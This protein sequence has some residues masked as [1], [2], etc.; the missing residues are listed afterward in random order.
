MH[1]TADITLHG[2]SSLMG[3][4]HAGEGFLHCEDLQAGF[5]WTHSMSSGDE[6]LNVQSNLWAT[7]DWEGNIFYSGNPSIAIDGKG[8]GK[9]IQQN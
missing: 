4:W 6:Y 1:T 2:K 9:L 5:V 3:C 8:K 7:I